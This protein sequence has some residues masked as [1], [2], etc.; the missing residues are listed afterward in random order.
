MSKVTKRNS[1]HK[2]ACHLPIDSV[3]CQLWA[4]DTQHKR[5]REISIRLKWVITLLHKIVSLIWHC[6]EWSH[7]YSHLVVQA[8]ALKSTIG[9]SLRDRV[10]CWEVRKWH[11]YYGTAED[12]IS[13]YY[14]PHTYVYLYKEDNTWIVAVFLFWATNLTEHCTVDSAVFSFPANIVHICCSATRPH[15]SVTS[16]WIQ[17]K[18]KYMYSIDECIPC[19]GAEFKISGWKILPRTT[20]EV[21][22]MNKLCWLLRNLGQK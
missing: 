6:Q 10:E 19:I 13:L 21:N 4:R 14:K 20:A 11:I 15:C 17:H 22:I 18:H 2:L 5:L 12:W 16:T 1:S 8:R 9:Q 3:W 7:G